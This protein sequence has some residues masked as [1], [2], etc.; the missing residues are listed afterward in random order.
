MISHRRREYGITEEQYNNMILYQNNTCAICKK[1]SHKTLHIDH[2]HQ[3]GN[4][5]GLLC[6]QCNTGIG[7][8]KEDINALASAI[9][10]LTSPTKFD[11]LDI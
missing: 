7:F 10:Y 2:D 8:F 9:E 4:V 6:S 11:I 5:R 1:P 3:T